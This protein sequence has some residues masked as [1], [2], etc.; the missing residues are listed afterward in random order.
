[1]VSQITEMKENQEHQEHQT[2]Q[3][4]HPPASD[5]HK[6]IKILMRTKVRVRSQEP[7]AGL[8]TPLTIIENGQTT[9]R[10]YVMQGEK[11]RTYVSVRVHHQQSILDDRVN[12][13]VSLVHRF[14]DETISKVQ[15][16][17]K[18]R[19]VSAHIVDS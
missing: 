6:Q 9:S 13:K 12:T 4:R 19:S 14:Q 2:Q 11:N 17:S 18:I 3:C 10:T 15:G 1:M 16:R 7:Y 5:L 8:Y